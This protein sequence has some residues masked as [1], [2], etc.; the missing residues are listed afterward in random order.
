[1]GLILVKLRSIH[2]L[3]NE[4]SVNVEEA[5]AAIWLVHPS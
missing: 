3:F 1:M 2:S 5:D 4:I